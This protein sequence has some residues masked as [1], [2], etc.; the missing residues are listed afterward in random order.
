MLVWLID[1]F[2]D[3]FLNGFLWLF[4]FLPL[5]IFGITTTILALIAVVAFFKKRE[6]SEEEMQDEEEFYRD[7]Y[8]DDFEEV[9]KEEFDSWWDDKD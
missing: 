8:E 1:F 6:S 3:I 9:S 7:L 4:W 5:A 2:K